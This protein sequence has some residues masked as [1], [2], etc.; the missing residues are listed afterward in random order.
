MTA[1]EILAQWD[2]IARIFIKAGSWLALL[3]IAARGTEGVSRKDLASF[4]PGATVYKTLKRWE[5][6]GLIT[7]E[8]ETHIHPTGHHRTVYKSQRWRITDK[9]L[10]LLRLDPEKQ[11]QIPNPQSAIE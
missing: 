6:A 9:A 1:S 8:L 10:Q 4:G 2:P 5:K 3:R 7:C 11:S